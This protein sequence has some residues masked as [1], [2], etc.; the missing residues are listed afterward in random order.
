MAPGRSDVDVLII[1]TG[2]A[3]LMAATWMARC[4][5]KTRIVDTRGIKIFSGPASGLQ[6][7]TL[8]VFDALRVADRA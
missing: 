7:R 2:P 8:E 5:A 6:C 1:G 3:G 4:A